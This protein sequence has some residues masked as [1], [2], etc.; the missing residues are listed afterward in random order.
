MLQFVEWTNGRMAPN[1][2]AQKMDL[3]YGLKKNDVKGAT[4]KT[5]LI[6]DLNF[7]ENATQNKK[8]EEKEE[9]EEEEEEN[10]NLKK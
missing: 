8:E 10:E 5:M 1:G 6:E 9:E 4:L 2:H 7:G 3:G